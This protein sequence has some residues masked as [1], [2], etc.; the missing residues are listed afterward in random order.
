MPR[1]ERSRSPHGA[2]A[3]TPSSLSRVI[4]RH[5]LSG[6]VWLEEAAS[7]I[8]LQELRRRASSATQ[9]PQS[10]VVLLLGLERLEG[11]DADKRWESLLTGAGG[12]TVEVLLVALVGE[13][14]EISEEIEEDMHNFMDKLG[15]Y[16]ALPLWPAIGRSK[17]C[18][19]GAF[20][21]VAGP[22]DSK[23]D[24][25]RHLP[26]LERC[27]RPYISL[28]L[29]KDAGFFYHNIWN[30]WG[31]VLP[32]A[33]AS[34]LDDLNVI[35]HF[36]DL[37]CTMLR[38][39]SH[40]LRNDAALLRRALAKYNDEF[41]LDELQD[42]RDVALAAVSRSGISLQIMSPELQDCRDVVIAAVTRDGSALAFASP[43]MQGCRDVVLV[44]VAQTG[45]ALQFASPE[46]QGC[47]DVVLVAV[48]QRADA[49]EFV[50][51]EMQGYRD[52]VLA[53]VA[54]RADALEFA[55][56]EMKGCRDV[57]LAAVAQDGRAL[58]FASPEMKGCRDAVLAAVSQDG[59]ALKFAFPEMQG[60]RDVVLAAVAQDGRALEFASPEMQ[61]CR[62]VV[63]AAI[64]QTGWAL[65]YAS[66][67]MQG[68]RDVVFA[69]VSQ[70][71]GALR[72]ASCELRGCRD[73][74]FAA[75]S[76]DG[77]A[78][79][80]VTVIMKPIIMW[81]TSQKP[82]SFFNLRCTGCGH[83]DGCRDS[84]DDL[85]KC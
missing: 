21:R 9:L 4:G 78:L 75:V 27:L 55:S 73:V 28:S 25:I 40:R 34:L 59:R 50:S 1:V 61:G 18:C 5:A 67:E 24:F 11:P 31:F 77:W 3:P 74:A 42:C 65:Q 54:Q 60:Y 26:D 2:L 69:A 41:A 72:Y 81:M 44:A 39:A 71:G 10:D 23:Q 15:P 83:R 29:L 57:V 13:C 80:H 45:R 37:D 53:A 49:L 79:Y 56:P 70:A 7:D 82:G 35:K 22:K 32:W 6:R 14:E 58:E 12:E 48:A 43:E 84:R 85:P 8:G 47:R 17:R 20:R 36:V 33:D 76:Q 52:V 30:G 64:A 38:Y 51:P 16:N 66:H 63:L 46:I 68:R 62:D 19:V